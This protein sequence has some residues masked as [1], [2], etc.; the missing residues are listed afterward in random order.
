MTPMTQSAFD[1]QA[2]QTKFSQGDPELDPQKSGLYLRYHLL[3]AYWLDIIH[4]SAAALF[5]EKPPQAEV[6]AEIRT[7]E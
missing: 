4:R 5:K 3:V 7:L 2:N 1:F 6:E